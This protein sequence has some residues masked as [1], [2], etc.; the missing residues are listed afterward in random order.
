M[1][2]TMRKRSD[3]KQ[4]LALDL[5]Q[6]ELEAAQAAAIDLEHVG[7]QGEEPALAGRGPEQHGRADRAIRAAADPVQ[8][9]DPL[10]QPT[11]R[12]GLVE[13][14][15]GAGH[16]E[17]A[18]LAAELVGDQHSAGALRL[19][20]AERDLAQLHLRQ[21]VVD[22]ADHVGP[23]VVAQGLGE[24]LD[25]LEDPFRLYRCHTIMNCA[26]TCPKG[27]NPAKAIAEIKKM[28]VERQA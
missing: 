6:E 26:K 15:H 1:F 2:K 10:L 8:A 5:G 22:R 7:V 13:V 9:A 17:V 18:S 27:L 23:E 28:M 25:D 20:E 12:P 21:A 4:S 24:R 3:K 11:H 19:L 14:Q 16:L